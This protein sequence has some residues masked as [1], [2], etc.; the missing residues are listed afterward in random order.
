MWVAVLAAV[1]ALIGSFA[2]AATALRAARATE[3]AAGKSADSAADAQRFAR[4]AD[5]FA[6]WQMHKRRI[7]A[8]VLTALQS[9]VKFQERQLLD[10]FDA[11]VLNAYPELLATLRELRTKWPERQSTLSD[12]EFWDLVSKMITDIQA[13]PVEAYGQ[14]HAIRD[15]LPPPPSASAAATVKHQNRRADA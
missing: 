12:D 5:R 6:E 10:A 4:A 7:Y 3:K 13:R 8:E 1:V 11:A 2:G 9:D 15:P 14:S